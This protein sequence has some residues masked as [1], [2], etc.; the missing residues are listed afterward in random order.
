MDNL[1]ENE[2]TQE[3]PQEEDEDQIEA[4]KTKRR[5]YKETSPDDKRRKEN[6]QRTPAQQA[7]WER[8]VKAREEKRNARK[9]ELNKV[10]A[11]KVVKKAVIAKKNQIIKEKIIDDA[12]SDSDD[13]PDEVIQ[14]VLAK[15]RKN[16]PAEQQPKPR[17]VEKVVYKEPPAPAFV[18]V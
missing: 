14:K 9:E 12:I 11:E 18:F 4:P 17:V 15:T 8:C 1:E 7:A 10:I 5:V 6:R 13:I 2:P 16:K 3:M